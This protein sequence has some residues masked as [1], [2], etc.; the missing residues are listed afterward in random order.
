M[1]TGLKPKPAKV[2]PTS[3]ESIQHHLERVKQLFERALVTFYLNNNCD[4][5]FDSSAVETNLTKCLRYH[6]GRLDGIELGRGD[7][8]YAT[9]TTG[10]STASAAEL[11][12]C[13]DSIAGKT[14][15]RY[16]RC[17]Q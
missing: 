2:S 14:D 11:E 17:A 1:R 9:D 15:G 3:I 6:T 16:G 5:H 13:S 10:S 8:K 4:V 12:P 7:G